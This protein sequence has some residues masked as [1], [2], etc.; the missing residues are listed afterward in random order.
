MENTFGVEFMSFNE[1]DRWPNGTIPPGTFDTHNAYQ[2][3]TIIVSTIE[4][5]RLLSSSGALPIGFDLF[6]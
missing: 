2:L 3:K 4:M 5:M 6:L 1:P